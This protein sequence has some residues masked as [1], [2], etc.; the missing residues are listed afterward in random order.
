MSKELNM[1]RHLLQSV[2]QNS[3]PLLL[4][5]KRSLICE[6]DLRDIAVFIKMSVT[7]V[8]IKQGKPLNFSKSRDRT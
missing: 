6:W 1:I 2:A 5:H 7:T 4:F 8:N 3:N